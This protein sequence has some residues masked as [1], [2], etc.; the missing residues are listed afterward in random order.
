[1]SS[2]NWNTLSKQEKS[3][4]LKSAGLP[5]GLS[6][7]SWSGL[8]KSER[9]KLEPHGKG[10][11]EEATE[12]STHEGIKKIAK[13]HHEVAIKKEASKAN[14]TPMQRQEKRVPE[15]PEIV[16]NAMNDPITDIGQLT[17]QQLRDLNKFVKT[18]VL[19]KGKGSIFPQ[20]KTVYA[21]KGYDIRGERERGLKELIQEHEKY[22]KPTE[23]KTFK[24]ARK[25][26]KG[27]AVA[28]DE[29]TIQAWTA[30]MIARRFGLN[31]EAV[32]NWGQKHNV[33]LKNIFNPKAAGDG[34]NIIE[35][36]LND[37]E[38]G[39]PT[40]EFLRSKIH[41]LINS[42]SSITRE[43]LNKAL[44]ELGY[45][46]DTFFNHTNIYTDTQL[47]GVLDVMGHTKAEPQPKEPTGKHFI[48]IG[49][50]KSKRREYVTEVHPFEVRWIK[51]FSRHEDGLW[52]VTEQST[53]IQIAIGRTQKEAESNATDLIKKGDT[54]ALM[55]KLK[56]IETEVTPTDLR[57]EIQVEQE[58]KKEEERN[59]EA[60]QE[61]IG[62]AW[63]YPGTIELMFS[64]VDITIH[65]YNR[66]HEDE[67]R[68]LELGVFDKKGS[69]LYKNRDYDMNMT[70]DEVKRIV[71]G[72]S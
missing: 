44:E 28:A 61:T 19:I 20:A 59:K 34:T 12:V 43:R 42:P 50:G 21:K 55:T 72:F 71:K 46:S 3:A 51:L 22:D 25:K 57:R 68:N 49:I 11:H 60:I 54:E 17:E 38:L 53:G 66:N 31:P 18:G 35:A 41:D 48:T 58:K 8:Q 33:I 15:I 64:K 1:M 13:R 6:Q 23:H 45:N 16:Q 30:E 47:Q 24:E 70:P 63:D 39:K 52:R 27:G 69:V 2:Q 29:T 26:P 5:L 9:K 32:Y 36:V 62:F 37:T 65:Y 40:N 10:W 7:L 67:P 4:L 14:N 56:R